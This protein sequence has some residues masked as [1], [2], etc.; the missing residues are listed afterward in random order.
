MAGACR[1]DTSD[2]N[3]WN[4]KLCVD[5]EMQESNSTT[6]TLSILASTRRILQQQLQLQQTNKCHLAPIT[7]TAKLQ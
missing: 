2:R 5:K 6:I 3:K 7:I 1:V 4:N